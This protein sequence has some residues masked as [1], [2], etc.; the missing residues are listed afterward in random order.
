MSVLRDLQCEFQDASIPWL[1]LQFIFSTDSVEDLFYFW[2]MTH[3]Q[4]SLNVFLLKPLQTSLWIQDQPINNQVHEGKSWILWYNLSHNT[5]KILIIIKYI[6]ISLFLHML[7]R[8]KI[9][10]WEVGQW[11]IN[12]DQFTHSNTDKEYPCTHTAIP[13]F[14]NGHV[15]VPFCGCQASLFLPFLW[16]FFL[17][18]SFSP[19]SYLWFPWKPS[20]SCKALL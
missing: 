15:L 20:S 10:S 11:Q 2:H 17:L 4:R 19:Q 5:K 3:N 9:Q 1:K 16:D 8:G 7:E 12:V 13:H 18:P 6:Q 14:S